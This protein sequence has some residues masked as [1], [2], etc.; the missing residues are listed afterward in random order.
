MRDSLLEIFPTQALELAGLIS[1]GSL[2]YGPHPSLRV[3]NAERDACLREVL[4]AVGDS[5]RFFTNHGHA[6]DGA[7]ADFLASSF[8]A[9]VLAG[10]TID[11]C[12]IGVSDEN[13]LVLWRFEDD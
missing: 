2:L 8:H 6:E 9:N 10:P 11:I 3:P 5:A 13:V 1:V 12:L 4:G 7:E